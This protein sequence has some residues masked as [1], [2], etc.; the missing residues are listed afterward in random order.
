MDRKELA[1]QYKHSSCNCAQAVLKAF[2]DELDVSSDVLMKIGSGFGT[3]MGCLE[4]TCGALCAATMIAGLKNDSGLP[5][6]MISRQ[7]LGNFEKKSGA[8]ICR[9]LK[10]IDTGKVVC[11]CDDC[12]RNA[13]ACI[14]EYLASDGQG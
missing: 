3:G 13:V 6:V 7:L 14:E 4:A 1:V 12:V 11:E 10:G 5:T 9:V 8:T 2:E